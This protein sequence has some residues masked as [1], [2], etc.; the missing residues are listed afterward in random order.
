MDRKDFL[1]DGDKLLDQKKKRKT[2][3][4]RG[5]ASEQYRCQMKLMVQR[6]IDGCCGGI[7]TNGNDK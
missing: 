5:N 1:Q 3:M 7:Y 4:V 2:L 6:K